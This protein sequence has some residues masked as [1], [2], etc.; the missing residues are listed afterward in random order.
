MGIRIVRRIHVLRV[1]WE[2]SRSGRASELRQ[3]RGCSL[4]IYYSMVL[5]FESEYDDCRSVSMDAWSA[6]QLQR[7]QLGG[8]DALNA[9]L[10]NYGV[11]KYTDIRDKYNSQAA[12]VS[13]SPCWLLLYYVHG[14][15][16]RVYMHWSNHLLEACV[17]THQ[18]DV[19]CSFTETKS[20][21]RLRAGITALRHHQHQTAAPAGPQ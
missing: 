2:A 15:C 19:C 10:K 6:E 14:S 21:L 12:E 11:D 7:M 16:A 4:A 13:L 18:P 3:V 1:Q 8:N 5:H 17:H 9:F 20:E